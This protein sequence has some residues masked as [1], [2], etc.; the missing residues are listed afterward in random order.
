[1]RRDTE[2]GQKYFGLPL[3]TRGISTDDNAR[4]NWPAKMVQTVTTILKYGCQDANW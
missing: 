4:N 1:V 2:Q 3:E